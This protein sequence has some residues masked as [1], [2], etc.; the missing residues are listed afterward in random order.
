MVF[1]TTHRHFLSS[2]TQ[3][4]ERLPTVLHGKASPN[5][6]TTSEQEGSTLRLAIKPSLGPAGARPWILGSLTARL[7]PPSGKTQESVFPKS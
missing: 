6:L 7:A 3:N 2:L 4:F 1:L 5:D